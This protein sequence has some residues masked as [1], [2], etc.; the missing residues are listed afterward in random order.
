MKNL[1]ELVARESGVPVSGL[2]AN[3][4]KEHQRIVGLRKSGTGKYKVLGIDK[5]DGTDW[6]HG[7][8][9]TAKKALEE[10]RKMTKEAMDSASDSSIATVYYAY[11]PSGKY[12]GG[13]AWN[14]Q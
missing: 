12:L 13:D 5:F 7:E 10:A 3:L 9:K 11:D 6:V 4:E 2:L 8:Y 1:A 14:G